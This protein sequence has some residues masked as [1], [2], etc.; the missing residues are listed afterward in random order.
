MILT[1]LDRNALQSI[2]VVSKPASAD[3][4]TGKAK[5]RTEVRARS[6][7]SSFLSCFI[8]VDEILEKIYANMS[9][10]HLKNQNYKRAVETADKVNETTVREP[11]HGLI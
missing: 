11:K 2:G 1:I 6:L 3:E 7:P 10:C 5:E 4:A 9:A 8:Q